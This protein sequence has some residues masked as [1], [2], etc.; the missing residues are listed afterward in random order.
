MPAKI[1]R[2][3]IALVCLA[4]CLQLN[5]PAIRAQSLNFQDGFSD[6]DFTQNPSWIGDT[7]QFTIAAG[8][9]NF[10]QQLLGDQDN[11]GTAYLVAPSTATIG[12]WEFY[13]NYDGFAPS[14]GNR[15]EIILM[16]DISELD[17]P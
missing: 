4:G 5:H 6:G 2:I 12:A 11:G 15:A 7:T 10:Q 8:E 13:I 1:P 14:D 16:S 3:A 17:G 9:G